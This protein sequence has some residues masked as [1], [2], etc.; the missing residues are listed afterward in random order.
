MREQ[1]VF[2]ASVIR[3]DPVQLFLCEQV[4]IDRAALIRAKRK[5]FKIAVGNGFCAAEQLVLD[6]DAELA[7]KI[8]AWFIGLNHSADQRT[9]CLWIDDIR[10]F[11]YGKHMADSVAD[12]VVEIKP[13]FPE[14]GA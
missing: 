13:G 2:N 4:R 10:A 1:R 3:V 8:N 9:F 11:M 12:A 6:A 14:R 7:F 5:C